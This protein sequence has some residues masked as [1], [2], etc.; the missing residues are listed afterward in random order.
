MNA[1]SH[2][3][4]FS[5][6]ICVAYVPNFGCFSIGSGRFFS[7]ANIKKARIQAILGLYACF[8]I[9]GEDGI[10]T[11]VPRRT[12]G[13]QDRLVMTAPTPLQV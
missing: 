13:F 7:T 8:C 3:A 4:A 9:R 6:C 2:I 5:R 10:R 12:N 1:E 11:H